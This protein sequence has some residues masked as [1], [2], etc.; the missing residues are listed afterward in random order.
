M[1]S[2]Q[3]TTRIVSV[4]LNTV[5]SSSVAQ[6]GDNR[7]TNLKSRA[8]AVQ[9]AVPNFEQDEA[10]FASYEIFAKPLLQ[11]VTDMTVDIRMDPCPPDIEIGYV[12]VTALS[13]SALLRAGCGGPL[14][15]QTRILHIR[16]FNYPGI[17]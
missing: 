8:I 15:A 5:G 13:A 1:R 12:D 4:V 7:A 10:R 16:H 3:R 2:G 11:L 17:R 14:T 9:R 6:F